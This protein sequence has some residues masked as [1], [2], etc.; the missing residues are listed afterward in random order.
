M[1]T[2]K[3]LLLA[4]AAFLSFSCAKENLKETESPASSDKE[5]VEM[6]FNAFAGEETKTAIGSK[7]EDGKYPVNWVSTD[8]IAV[9]DAEYNTYKFDFTSGEGTKATFSGKVPSEVKDFYA[10]YPYMEGVL[11]DESYFTNVSLPNDQTE[12]AS[13]ISCGVMVAHADADKNLKFKNVTAFIKLTIPAGI[14][15]VSFEGANKEIITGQLSFQFDGTT[16]SEVSAEGPNATYAFFGDT[17]TELK[18]G[19]Y[20]L[21]VA[22]VALPD[23]FIVTYADI[24]GVEKTEIGTKDPN[25]KPGEI[26][27]L[28]TRDPFKP[29]DLTRGAAWEWTATDQTWDKAGIQTIGGHDWTLSSDNTSLYLGYDSNKGQQWGSGN[30][31]AKM[32]SLSSNYGETYG[33]DE[34]V[35]NASCANKSDAKLEVTIGGKSLVCESEASVALT[36]SATEYT[37]KSSELVAGDIVIKYTQTTKKAMYL[38]AIFINPKEKTQL[39][40]PTNL[41]ATIDETVKNKINVSWDAVENAGSYSVTCSGVDDP[42]EVTTTS[43]SFDNLDWSTDYTITVV[44]KVAKGDAAHLDSDAVVSETISIGAEPSLTV[45]APKSLTLTAQGEATEAFKVDTNQDSWDAESSNDAF[46]VN[47]TS[48]GFTISASVNPSLSARTATITVTA[49]YA[50]QQTF[51]MTQSAGS[52]KFAQ[53]RE[54]VILNADKGDTKQVTIVSDYDW[55]AEIPADAKFSITPSSFIY[56]EGETAKSGT[57]K[58]QTVI[59]K[60]LENNTSEDGTLTLGAITFSNRQ[61]NTKLTVTV[62][63]ET[64]YVAPAITLSP[65]SLNVPAETTSAS[66]EVQSNVAWTVSTEADWITKC[67]ENGTGDDKVEITFPANEESTARTAE[68]TV[69][70]TDGKLTKTF[71]LTQK[72]SGA[73]T[74]TD[75]LTADDFKA[76]DN[77]YTDFSNVT[78]TSKAIYAG[79]SAKSDKGSIQLRSKQSNSGIVT[80]TSGG[81]AK[82]VKITIEEGSKTIDVYGANTAYTS[83]SDLYDSTKQGTKIGSTSKTETITISGSYNYIGIRSN[84][85][86]V[87]ISSIEIVWE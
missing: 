81:T 79:L 67:T 25:L 21:A 1:K 59:F 43:A 7:G 61:N 80:T 75:V 3:A 76:T 50:K 85:G 49:G 10:I 31:S 22:P 27:D 12:F 48:E 20:Y 29:V 69:A 23:G 65:E 34:V 78:K 18:A 77:G 39:S 86:A 35:V 16:V 87:Y 73:T 64:S 36:P 28:G 72:A 4:A 70:S 57:A 47:K 32:V 33:I 44:A 55:E 5:L 62:K 63:Q 41:K 13:N 17:E 68:F 51:K 71:K 40:T 60:A 56:A 14:T 37:F 54:E 52:F 84:S 38:K 24:N 19:T 2:S 66:F 58:S 82:S 74:I 45:T 6:T 15:Q 42:K 46:I 53:A 26:L 9:L 83:A 30:S 8:K 11:C